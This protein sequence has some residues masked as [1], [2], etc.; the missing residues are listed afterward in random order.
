MLRYLMGGYDFKTIV[1][2]FLLTI[3]TV[4]ISLSFHEY[5]HG[6]VA[7]KLG[8]PTAKSFGRLTLNPIKHFHPVGML[9]MLLIGIGY[10][11]P[12][13]INPRYFKDPKKGMALSAAAGP[14]INLLLAFFGLFIYALILRF[15]GAFMSAE[16]A[17][18]VI[19]FFQNFCYMNVYLAIFNMLPIPPFDGSRV[20]FAFLPD[21]HY[22]AVMKHERTI[23][24]VVLVAV[25]TG[26]LDAPFEFIT[27]KI[28]FGMEWL[29]GLIL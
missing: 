2:V 28:I 25:A 26:I 11:N 24:L 29:V 3:P 20:L 8:D 9:L 5:A 4:L 17:L 18:A 16:V 13:P 1:L 19:L 23:M 6:L 15:L 12:V 7:Y 10:A 14:T 27:D 21:K 22:F